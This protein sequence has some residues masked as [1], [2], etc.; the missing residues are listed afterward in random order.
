MFDMINL[1]LRWAG[2][3]HKRINAIENKWEID[4]KRMDMVDRN[5]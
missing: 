3:L 4:R 1:F 2:N 5:D